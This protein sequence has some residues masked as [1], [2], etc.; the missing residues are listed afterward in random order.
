MSYKVI[1]NIPNIPDYSL[2]SKQKLRE[3]TLEEKTNRYTGHIIARQQ[4]AKSLIEKY[5]L[6]NIDSISDPV[7]IEHWE[8][9]DFNVVNEIADYVGLRKPTGRIQ[10][11]PPGIMVPIHLDNLK[12]GYILYCEDNFQNHKFTKE[13]IELFSVNPNS[14]QRLLIFLED[15]RP[16]QGI[17]FENNVLSTWRKGDVVHWDWRDVEHATVN[18]G[19]WKRPLLR[20]TGLVTEKFQKYFEN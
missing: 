12:E 3:F 5:N 8:I 10:I 16:G 7:D 1:C 2:W 17:F 11:L 6:P 20:I 14:V 9:T 13:D 18:A 19:F 15:H 4:A